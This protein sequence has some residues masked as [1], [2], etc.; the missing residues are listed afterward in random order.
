MLSIFSCVCKPSV[1]LLWRNVCLDLWPIIG[2]K[3]KINKW[4]LIRLKS[5]STTK[6]NYKQGEK[7]A[8]RMG[9]NNSKWRNRQRINLK[10]IQAIPA[11]QF[12]KNKWPNQLILNEILTHTQESLTFPPPLVVSAFLEGRYHVSAEHGAEWVLSEYISEGRHMS[13]TGCIS[14]QS[15]NKENLAK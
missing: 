8:F 7:T 10:N 3:A 4:D 11:A 6:E 15:D 5:F 14:I 13:L 12:Q 9:E 1:C 2:I